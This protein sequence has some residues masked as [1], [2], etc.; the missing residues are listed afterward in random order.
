MNAFHSTLKKLDG[1]VDGQWGLFAKNIPGR[2]GYQCSN[3]YRKLIERGEIQD[4]NY[5]LDSNGKAR[6]LHKKSE[7]SQKGKGDRKKRSR[8]RPARRRVYTA[9]AVG[10]LRQVAAFVGELYK[11]VQA[12]TFVRPTQYISSSASFF[13]PFS[14]N[15]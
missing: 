6:F 11:A 13:L 10:S 4:P 1:K 15:D 14:L 8:A 7:P 9:R 2:V 12:S 3:M 5:V